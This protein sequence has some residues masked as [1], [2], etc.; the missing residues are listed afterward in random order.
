MDA[1]DLTKAPPRGPREQLAGLVMLPRTIDKV[2]ATL[3]GGSPGE[4]HVSGLSQRLLDALGI[5]LEALTQAVRDAAGDD[6][7]AQW[8]SAHSDPS[9][10]PEI[11]EAMENRAQSRM[12]AGARAVFEE[13]YG[14]DVRV[15]DKLFDVMEADDRKTFAAS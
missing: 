6:D 14:A 13:K 5:D 9:K 4:Y 2:R 11:N 10:Y 8:V 15:H 7:V 1:L 12:D 3:P